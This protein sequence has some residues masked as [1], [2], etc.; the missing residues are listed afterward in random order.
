MFYFTLITK[1][2]CPNYNLSGDGDPRQGFI[3]AGNRDEEEMCPRKRS[4]GSPRE[5]FF[6]A[7]TGMGSYSTTGNSPL[8]SLLGRKDDTNNMWEKMATCIRKVD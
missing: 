7:R 1:D 5:F 4:W 8:R 6:V 3:P 2:I